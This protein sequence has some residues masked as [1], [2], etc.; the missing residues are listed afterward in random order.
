M[1]SACLSCSDVVMCLCTLETNLKKQGLLPLTFANAADYDKI[2]STDKISLLGLKDFAPGK[3]SVSACHSSNYFASDRGV[4]VC[5]PV[6]RRISKTTSNN[7]NTRLKAFLSIT[8]ICKS[9]VPHSRHNHASISSL[10][11]YRP[12]ALPASQPTVPK[13]SRQKAHVQ[14]YM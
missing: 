8:T 12:D 4:C 1:L 2:Q 5:L 14:S 6:C 3:V 7:N 13:R 9:F 10:V 11:F